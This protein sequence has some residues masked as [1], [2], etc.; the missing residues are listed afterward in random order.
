MA[1]SE[2]YQRNFLHASTALV[3]RELV[4]RGCRCDDTLDLHQ[5]WD[6]FLQCAQYS[7]F[8]FVR[9]RTFVWHADIGSSGAGGGRNLDPLKARDFTDRVRRKWAPRRDRLLESLAPVLQDAR[10]CCDRCDWIGAASAIRAALALDPNNPDALAM[11]SVVERAHGRMAG[12]QVAAALAC[13]VR[14]DDAAL[15]YNLALVC[16]ERGDLATVRD[17]AGRLERMAQRDPRATALSA[18]LDGM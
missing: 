3:A 4:A 10:A 14:P 17:C 1:L 9:Q 11:T 12:A 18:Q 6:W 13:V 8:H 2:F 15:V 7:P 16:R 5:D